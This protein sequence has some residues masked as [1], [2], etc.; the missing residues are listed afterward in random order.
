MKL[1]LRT[2]GQ[3]GTS[4]NRPPTWMVAFRFA[5]ASSLVGL[6]SF[7]A[8]TLLSLV[9]AYFVVQPHAKSTG[10]AAFHLGVIASAWMSCCMMIAFLLTTPFYLRIFGH[11]TLQHL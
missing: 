6:L 9:S 1:A 8:G 4:Q 11:R 5:L 7:S 2:L 3:L 10:A